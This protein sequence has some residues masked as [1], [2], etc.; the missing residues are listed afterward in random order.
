M[1]QSGVLRKGLTIKYD[2]VMKQDGHVWVGYNTN[3]GKEYIY[4]LELG[5]KVQEN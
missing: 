4:Q 3:N 1:P 5:M 2:E